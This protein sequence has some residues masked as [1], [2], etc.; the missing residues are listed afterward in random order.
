MQSEDEFRKNVEQSVEALNDIGA[1]VPYFAF[2]WGRRNRMNV[3]VLKESK[4][5]PVLM[6]GMMNYDNA[7]QIHRELLTIE[8]E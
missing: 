1:Y 6:D 4:L 5:V 2:P 8:T 7:S 3:R